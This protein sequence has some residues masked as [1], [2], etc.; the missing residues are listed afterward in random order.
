[1]A[2]AAR[3]PVSCTFPARNRSITVLAVDD[4]ALSREFLKAHIEKLGHK[5]LVVENGAQAT[6][7]LTSGKET[8]DVVLMDREMPVMDGISAV[9]RMKQEPSLR[10]IPVI[11]ITALKSPE[12]IQEGLDAGV[13]YYLSKP[14][15]E[16]VFHSVLEAAIREAR[17][18]RTLAEELTKHR[19][20]FDM[21]DT[22]RFTYR[23]LPEAESLATFIANCFPDPE[24]ALWGLSE[25]MINAIEHGNLGLGYDNKT[26]LVAGGTWFD[27]IGCLQ[28]S[29]EHKEKKVIATITHKQGGVYVVIE[30]EGAGFDWKRYLQIDPARAGDNHGRGIAQANAMSFD[31]LTYNEK[32][33]KAVGFVSYK[34]QL[35]W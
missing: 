17:Q 3:R 28:Q 9:K 23:T 32:G 29:P 8:V 15:E 20:S 5:A 19:A 4:D 31:K 18:M 11:M 25:L 24:R 14:V 22:C 27:E 35:Q 13:F 21:I 16:K 7:L 30:D 33:N 34:T 1:M 2:Q 6:T 10:K 26:R 12:R